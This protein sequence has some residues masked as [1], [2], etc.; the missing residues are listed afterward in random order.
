MSKA[1][2]TIRSRLWLILLATFLFVYGIHVGLTASPVEEASASAKLI[3]VIKELAKLYKP[4][5]LSTM[6]FLLVKNSLTMYL[7][8]FAGIM[9]AFPSAI[10]VILNGF[11]VGVVGKILAEEH[12]AST[13][14]LSLATHGVFEVAALV[15]AGAFGLNL[16]LCVLKR[17]FKISSRTEV[18]LRDLIKLDLASLTVVGI[19]LL[20]IAAFMETFVTPMVSGLY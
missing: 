8:Y 6:V 10:V 2:E 16:G 5:S 4:Y 14:F 3:E 11:V 7:I 13:A 19:P 12:G 15:I 20:A 18:S 1:Y 17:V 9:L